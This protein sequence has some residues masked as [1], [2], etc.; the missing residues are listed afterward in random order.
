MKY[1]YKYLNAY[2]YSF[3]KINKGRISGSLTNTQLQYKDS[4]LAIDATTKYGQF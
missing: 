4:L 2:D 1:S 3:F